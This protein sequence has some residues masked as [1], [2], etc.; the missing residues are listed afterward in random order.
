MAKFRIGDLIEV[1]WQDPTG[2]INENLD[3]LTTTPCTTRGTVL[4]K[5]GNVLCLWTSRYPD[6][7]GDATAIDVRSID[8]WRVLLKKE[9]T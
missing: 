3:K 1:V 7:V 2:A 6:N 4:K 5:A 9:N 8:S